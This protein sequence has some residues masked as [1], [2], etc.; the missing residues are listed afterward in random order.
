MGA[1]EEESSL[2][3]I[4]MKFTNK[5]NKDNPTLRKMSERLVEKKLF[6]SN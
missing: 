1:Y 4:C 5:I 3:N 6:Q 2:A